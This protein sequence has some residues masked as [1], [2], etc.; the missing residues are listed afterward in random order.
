MKI[1]ATNAPIPPST[2]S[3]PYAIEFADKMVVLITD[4]RTGIV[5]R[6]NDRGGYPVGTI[7]Y[8]WCIENILFP[9]PTAKIWHGKIEIEV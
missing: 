5:V 4:G 3:C 6:S 2:P 7:R 9:R 8:D 1:T